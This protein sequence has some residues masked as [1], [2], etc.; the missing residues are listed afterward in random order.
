VTPILMAHGVRRCLLCQH[1]EI[2]IDVAGRFVTTTCH[3]C[4]A[5]LRIEFNPPDDPFL[6]ARIERI[7]DAGRPRTPTPVRPGFTR[8]PRAN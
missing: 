6:K 2:E 4:S 5:V 1:V 3:A 7:D 8:T